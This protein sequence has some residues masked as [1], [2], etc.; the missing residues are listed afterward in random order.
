MDMR[1]RVALKHHQ[2]TEDDGLSRYN[3]GIFSRPPLDNFR[4]LNAVPS[5]NLHYF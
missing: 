3:G 1:G 5:S 4:G 2:E